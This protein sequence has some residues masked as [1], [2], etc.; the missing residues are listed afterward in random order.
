M[1]KVKI[2]TECIP[3]LFDRAKF[4]CD[5]AFNNEKEKTET[6]AEIA[7]YIG[8]NLKP[9][10]IPAKLGTQRWRIIKKRSGIGDI[11][12][13]L[14]NDS[15]KV[16]IELLP[17]AQKFYYSLEDKVLALIKIAAAANSMEFGVKGHDFDN[18]NFKEDLKK[19]LNEKLVGDI[20]KIHDY[21]DKYEKI[22]YLTDNAG[23]VVFDRFIAEK[24]REMGKEV[25]ISPK[26]GAIINDATLEDIEDLDFKGF[27]IVP[28]G[29]YVGL[30]LDEAPQE[31]LDLFWDKDYL[32]FAKGMGYYESLSEFEDKLKG[33]LIY[34]LRAKCLS[35]SQA[36]GVN[37]GVLVARAV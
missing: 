29:S 21:L 7:Q 9:D 16:A 4:E 18:E 1:I 3:C 32:I 14:K 25:V 15:N 27:S 17:L 31:F 34:V 24:F 22:L 6:L 37:R 5:L 10:I 20:E 26:N 2:N 8:A 28:S 36:L 11:Y 33:R 23:E 30:S 35:V 19:I 13:E 12:K